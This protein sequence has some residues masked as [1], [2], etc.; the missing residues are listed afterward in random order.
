MEIIAVTIFIKRRVGKTV[1]VSYN[2][3]VGWKHRKVHDLYRNIKGG[4]ELSIKDKM[5]ERET[6]DLLAKVELLS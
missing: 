6:K 4:L 3:P 2:A 1:I 5:I